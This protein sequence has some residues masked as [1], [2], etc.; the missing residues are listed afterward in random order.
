M[1]EAIKISL[2]KGKHIVRN[3]DW[4][5]S[6]YRDVPFL[7]AEIWFDYY[8]SGKYIRTKKSNVEIIR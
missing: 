5:K 7:N 6:F 4:I 3:L 1:S 2:T 8:F